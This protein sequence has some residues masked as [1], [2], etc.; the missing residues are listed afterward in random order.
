M[1]ALPPN[2]S[3]HPRWL[4]DLKAWEV[5]DYR[6]I[7][8]DVLESGYGIISYTWGRWA[9]WEKTPDDLPGGLNWKIP[10]VQELPLS[11]AR[12]VVSSLQIQYVWWDWMCVPQG[13]SQTLSPEL[14]QA[15]GEEVGKQM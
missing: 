2:N 7:A 4:L 3:E 10:Y 11:L 13:N 5:R 8:S 15:K 6:E 12:E 9:D 14:L 1:A